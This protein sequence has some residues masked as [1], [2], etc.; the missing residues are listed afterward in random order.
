MK[1]LVYL[2]LFISFFGYSQTQITDDNFYSAINTCL[3]TNPVDGLCSDSEYGAMPD[4]DVSNV[5]KMSYAFAQDSNFNTDIS[6]WDVSSVSEMR[7]MFYYNLAFNQDISS[8]DVSSVT[9]MS[10]MFSGAGA[11][12]R[13]ISSWDVSSVTNMS[14]MF[15]AAHTFNQ[16][17]SSWDVSKVTSMYSMF[18][19]AYA[20][21]QAIGNWNVSN[22][23]NMSRMFYKGQTFNQDLS[24]WDVSNVT[25]MSFMFIGSVLSTD[26]YDNILNGWSQ[27]NVQH[28]V[29]LGAQGIKYCNGEDARQS[30]IDNHNWIISDDG[31]DCSTAGVDDQKQLDIS[32]YPNPTN[33]KLFIQGL[34]SSSKVSIYN[35]LG[36][37]VLSQTISKEIDVN[38]LQSG[39]YI[40]KI[41]DEQKEIVRKFIK[42]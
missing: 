22:V 26:N 34:S 42:D 4:W 8:W 6:N 39:I 21:D 37:L 3:T 1:K 2:F 17:V 38:N 40:I 33:D 14:Y 15:D 41:A 32:I 23:T 30:L 27:Q 5:T 7:S 12:N 31:L 35:V 36:K 18:I 13:D 25:D 24:F 19:S 10:S 28:N 20:F 9:D 11:F 16:D 29:S